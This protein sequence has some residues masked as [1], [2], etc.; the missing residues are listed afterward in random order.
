MI[1]SFTEKITAKAGKISTE[2]TEYF[3]KTWFLHLFRAFHFFRAFAVTIVAAAFFLYPS[4]TP[5]KAGAKKETLG[6][7][8]RNAQATISPVPGEMKIDTESELF[9]NAETSFRLKSYKD[10]LNLYDEYLSK[11]PRGRSAPE[12]LMREGEIYTALGD[13]KTAR[14]VW[15]HILEKYPDCSVVSQACVEMLASFY[16]EGQYLLV[17]SFADTVG[18]KISSVTHIRRLYALLGDAYIATGSAINA[19][20]FYNKALKDADAGE[21]A[22][23]LAKLKPAVEKLNQEDIANLLEKEEGPT[24]AWLMYRLA[25]IYA[26]EGKY[27]DAQTLLSTYISQFP[28]HAYVPEARQLLAEYGGIPKAD[29]RTVGCLLPFTGSYAIYGNKAWKGIQLA[30]EQF[31]SAEGYPPLNIVRKDTASDPDTSLNAVKELAEEGV[32]AIIG[33]I[34]TADSAAPEAQRREIPI[35][36]LSQKEGITQIGDYVFRNF[37]TPKMQAESLVSYSVKSLGLKTF[38]VLYPAEKYGETYMK[39]FWDEVNAQGGKVAGAESYQPKQTDFS[40]AIRKLGRGF[41]G[42]FIPDGPEKVGLILPQLAFYDIVNVRLLG[43]NLW[44]SQK[45]I[46]TSGKFIQGAVFPDIFFADSRRGAVQDFVRD[47]GQSFGGEPPGFIE[48]IA[49]D[50][51]AMLFRLMMRSDIQSKKQLRDELMRL[52]DFEGVTGPT[53]FDNTGEA[54]KKLYLLEVKKGRCAE[55]E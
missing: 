4:C 32:F 13:H 34:A 22:Q 45:L 26:D 31:G 33:P 8:R 19:V 40:S 41:D 55:I 21:K 47:F 23:I 1:R 24:K 16:R 12:A 7:D 53:F 5:L 36:T 51:A 35:I 43:T 20:H 25:R 15:Q 18:R 6:S 48:A 9:A 10:A 14:N 11:F 37:L 38:A 50:T 52:R 49:F 54:H 44:H 17:I 30:L 28:E 46:Q 42:L 29:R 2:E 3:Q 39:A 27:E